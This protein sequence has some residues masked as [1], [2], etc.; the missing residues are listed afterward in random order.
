MSY[1]SLEEFTCDN[2]AC[3]KK[4]RVDRRSGQGTPKGWVTLGDDQCNRL[5]FC[6]VTCATP[7]L[8]RFNP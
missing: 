1:E 7:A 8:K 5:H 6:S 4:A 2:R 3:E